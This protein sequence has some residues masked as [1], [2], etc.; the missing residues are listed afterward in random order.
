MYYVYLIQSKRD[1][2]IYVG[3][4]KNLRKRLAEHN[5]GKSSFTA[6]KKPFRPVYYEAYLDLRDAKQREY[7]LKQYGSAIGHLKKR[8]KNSLQ[9]P[10]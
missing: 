9:N 5:S 7:K 4:T 1:G 3:Y 10:Y 8:L 2:E 6:R